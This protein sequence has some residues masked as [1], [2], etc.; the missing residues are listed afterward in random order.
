MNVNLNY[1]YYFLV[2]KREKWVFSDFQIFHKIFSF[3]YIVRFNWILVPQI[4][5]IC[6]YEYIN[7]HSHQCSHQNFPL[8]I[9]NLAILYP[10]P[11]KKLTKKPRKMR[12]WLHSMVWQGKFYIYFI[13]FIKFLLNN[14]ISMSFSMILVIVLSKNMKN[15]YFLT[16]RFSINFS[17]LRQ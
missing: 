16:F 7:S 14:S 12:F 8:K 6:Y 10:S 11:F 15:G 9:L 3:T 13:V 1:F 4:G 5:L 2:T 17:V